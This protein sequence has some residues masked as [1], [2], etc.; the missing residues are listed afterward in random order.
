MTWSARENMR[1][2]GAGWLGS[3][4]LHA[5]FLALCLS[6]TFRPAAPPQLK[7]VPVDLVSLLTIGPGQPG[8][9]PLVR[10]QPRPALAPTRA[11]EKPDAIKP[12]VD[13]MEARIAALA[14][15]RAAAAPLP[16]P[17]NDGAAAG[18]GDGAG[19]ALADFVRAQILRKWWPKLE[20]ESARATPVAMR[21]KISRAGVLSDIR[22]V[23]QQRFATDRQFRDM[24]LSA[25][26]AAILASPIALPP[27]N[28]EAMKEI[29]ITLDPRAVLR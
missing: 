6:W 23:D 1:K 12:P 11:G 21:L 20:T 9:A 18:N 16:A 22:I 25:R 2:D 14:N 17:D 7:T 24:A 5:A 10:Q 29:A 8:G 28:Y 19:Y 3:L 4:L 26:N 13:E 15:L 27:G